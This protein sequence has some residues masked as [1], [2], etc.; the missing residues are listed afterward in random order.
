M[1]RRH[2]VSHALGITT[3]LAAVLIAAAPVASAHHGPPYESGPDHEFGEM[4]DY[5]LVFPVQGAYTLRDT[6]FAGRCCEPGE[7]HHAQ[8]IMAPKMTP[9]VAAASG[10]IK[11]VNWS[12]DADPAPPDDRCCTLV[13][14]HDDGWE[15]WYLHLNNDT[16]GTDDGDGWGIAPGIA[17]GVHVDAGQLI[18]WVGDSGNA[19]G[20][21]S[22]LHFELKD[23][24]GIIVNPLEAL[25]AGYMHPGRV[26][27]ANRYLTAI[28]ISKRTHP[29]GADVVYVAVGVNFPDA[30]AAGP[31]AAVEG[32]PIL[33]ATSTVVP[34][35]AIAELVRLDPSLVVILGGPAAIADAV[36][37]QVGDTLPSAAVERRFGAT[38]Y[39]TAVET[40]KAVFPSSVDTVFI[41]SGEDYPDA[42]VAAPSA[43]VGG[44]PLLLVR[45]DSVPDAVAEELQRLGP[46][47]IVI[48]GGTAAISS[49]VEEALDAFAPQVDRISGSDRYSVSAALSA[50]QFP[51]GAATV[52]VAV[53]TDFADALAGGPASALDGAPLLLVSTYAIP[54]SVA[55]ELDRI[56]PTEIVILGGPAAISDGVAFALDAYVV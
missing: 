52:Y 37:T 44:N 5:P 16:P 49:S 14:D 56:G 4:V 25:L 45:R 32:A 27:G 29:D 55:A 18:G 33:L 9:V 54:P 50:A 43:A 35:E 47:R 48:V 24:Y 10:I 13:I 20:T 51:D 8:D 3:V 39:E 2:T 38:R 40:S 7:I 28:E 42:L 41:A 15:S 53:G 12:R 21:S 19:E 34:A 22:H 31:A 23:E 11:Y 36:L 17:P 46:S 26:A 30:L 6:F 1:R